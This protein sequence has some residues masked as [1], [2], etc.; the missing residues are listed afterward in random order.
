MNNIKQLRTQSK[1]SQSQFANKFDIP[2]RTLQKW[3]QNEADP[4][5][6]LEELIKEKLD[7][8]DFSDITKFRVTPKDRFKR[9][10]K[11]NYKNIERVNPIQQQ[12]LFDLIESL[13]SFKVVNK[14]IVFG[15]SITHKCHEDSDIDIYVELDEN[16][17]VKAYN[18]DC[19][20]D[21][22]NNF[23]VTEEMK[24]EIMSKG[25]IVYDR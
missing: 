24:K 15:S 10:I 7:L 4:L 18:V 2:V 14:V 1:L 20:V 25:V 8:E 6:Y 12:R 5:S 21:Y 16:V 11:G 23:T 17:N 9:V 19:P 22:W 3:E 13:K